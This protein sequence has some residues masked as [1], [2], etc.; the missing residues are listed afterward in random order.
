MIRYA[1]T[2]FPSRTRSLVMKLFA[3]LE[4]GWNCFEENEYL[5]EEMSFMAAIF[6]ESLKGPIPLNL[7]ENNFSHQLANCLITNLQYVSEHTKSPVWREEDEMRPSLTI[8]LLTYHISV[9]VETD[10]LFNISGAIRKVRRCLSYIT[11]KWS[12]RNF[13]KQT[14]SYHCTQ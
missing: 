4:M 9:A 1:I 6:D 2:Y 11:F 7:I 8:S 13:E 12:T 3:V 10:L 14:L 5:A